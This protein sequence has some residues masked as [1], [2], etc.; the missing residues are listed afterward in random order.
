MPAPRYTA[1]QSAPKS[2]FL[3]LRPRTLSRAPARVLHPGPGRHGR[4]WT[5]RSGR[6]G[7]PTGKRGF[8]QASGG[9]D[10]QITPPSEKGPKTRLKK[11]MKFEVM[12]PVPE[13]LLRC[14]PPPESPDCRDFCRD[15]PSTSCASVRSG[16]QSC[17]GF[18]SFWVASWSCSCFSQ[19]AW[20][21]SR[22]ACLPLS[23]LFRLSWRGCALR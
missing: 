23:S 18:A 21:A 3:R 11:L 6:V 8:R 14:F 9:S 13:I 1:R 20:R 5:P 7:F 2:A 22:L 17:F 15:S 10:G 16:E 19:I 12:A 4:V